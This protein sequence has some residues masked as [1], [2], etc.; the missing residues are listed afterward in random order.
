MSDTNASACCEQRVTVRSDED[1]KL[2]INRLSR[3][4]GQIRG[5]K[6][7]IESDTY[8][9]DILVQSSA[10]AAAMNSFN[11]ELMAKHVRGCLAKE[12]TEEGR[13]TI[14]ELVASLQALMK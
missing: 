8:C 4:E 14:D 13:K 7:M 1:K 12:M 5:V 10:A 11:R 2:L 9:L 6:K 3:I